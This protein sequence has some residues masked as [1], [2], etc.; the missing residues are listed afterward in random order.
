MADI[1]IDISIQAAG[2][3]DEG[4]LRA[5]AA[6]AAEALFALPYLRGSRSELSLVFTD[7]AAIRRLNAAW[8]GKD[9]ATNVLS[10]PAFAL[11]PGEKPQALLGDV[12]LAYETVKA[13]AEAEHKALDHHI[14]HLILHGMLHLLGYDHEN[15]EEAEIMEN[16]ERQILSR[17]GIDDPYA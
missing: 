13:E 2:W 14:S 3:A 16:L 6:P 9:K 17:L 8:R 10:F 11:Q 15:D 7:N 4:A 12:V 5:L 1:K